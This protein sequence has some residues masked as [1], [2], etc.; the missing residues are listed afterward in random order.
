LRAPGDPW[1]AAAL[2]GKALPMAGYFEWMDSYSVGDDDLD[3]DHRRLISIIDQFIASVAEHRTKEVTGRILE[4]LTDYTVDHFRREEEFM[5]RVNYPDYAQ[6]RAIHNKL[7][8]R[9]TEFSVG[10][11]R[12]QEDPA[13]VAEFLME[14]LLHHI[15]EDDMKYAPYLRKQPAQPA[16][17]PT[18]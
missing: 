17:A 11:R 12:E 5:R 14:W 13:A 15:L 7:A 9:V 1:R 3:A 6:H 8:R 4:Q 16:L 10:W 2:P 18:P